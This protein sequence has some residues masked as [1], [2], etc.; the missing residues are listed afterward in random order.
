M[1]RERTHNLRPAIVSPPP[2]LIDPRLFV[3]ALF[4]ACALVAVCGARL[5][6]TAA[7]TTAPPV[8]PQ[9]QQR[10]A[11]RRPR[12][13]RTGARPPAVDY[14]KFSHA[15]K[16]HYEDCASCHLTQTKPQFTLEKPDIKEYPD[17]PA[18][19]QCHRTQFFRGPLRGTAPAIC[20]DCHAAASPRNGARFPFP[21]PQQASQFSDTFPHANHAKST[22][23]KLFA[24]ALGKDKVKQ[25]DTCFYCHKVDKTEYKPPAG[26]KDAFVPPPGTFMSTP[27]THANCF[28]CHWQKGVENKDIEPLSSQCAD[29][30]KNLALAARPP[31]PASSPAATPAKPTATPAAKP[32]ATPVAKPT[33][34]PAKSVVKPTPTPAPKPAAKPTP[35]PA[36]PAAMPAAK[37]ATTPAAKPSPTATPKP[38]DEFAHAS[39]LRAGFALPVLFIPAVSLEQQAKMPFR[40]SPKFVHELDAHKTRTDEEGKPQKITCLTC[41]ATVKTSKSLETL[42]EP[43]NK[44]QLPACA[45]SAC[46]TSLSGSATLK[47]SIYRELRER[48]KDAKFDCAL[49]HLPPVST[50]EVPCDHYATVFQSAV[51]EGKSTKTLETIIPARCPDAA[52]PP[53]AA[54]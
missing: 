51:K 54:K 28:Q 40:T 42:R 11:A 29:C 23:L 5:A 34:T 13:R 44:V 12:P 10:P 36:K 20:A 30:H 46:H 31:A 22:A 21:K 45:S 49:C 16:G 37:P 8:E 47:L 17:H 24:P 6:P 39:Y 25:Q 19:I 32:T 15:T 1:I 27:T 4:A 48:S 41:H 43:A 52:K 2:R 9:Q 18:C 53:P 14:T 33:A 50:G 7:A 26:A 38:G 35:T 3:L